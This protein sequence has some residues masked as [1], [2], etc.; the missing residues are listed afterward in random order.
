MAAVANGWSVQVSTPLKG[1]ATRPPAFHGAKSIREIGNFLWGLEAYFGAMD[2]EDDAQKVSN[3]AFFLKDIAFVWWHPR[4]DEVRMDPIPSTH[5]MRSRE[6]SRNNSIPRML[7]I[8]LGLS[9]NALSIK[10]VKLENISRS[11]KSYFWRFR[12]WGSAT[13]SFASS[14]AFKDGPRWS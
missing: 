1:I 3:A 7:K 12:A 11:S 13:D 9:F 4:C 8:R 10:M 2:I 5:G 14:M 6:N